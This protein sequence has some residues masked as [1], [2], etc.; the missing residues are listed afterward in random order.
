MISRAAQ[1]EMTPH[2]ANAKHARGRI[3]LSGGGLR[4]LGP[5]GGIGMAVRVKLGLLAGLGA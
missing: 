1:D 2:Q 3:A 5:V 4:A